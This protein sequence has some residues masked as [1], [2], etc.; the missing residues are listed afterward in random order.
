MNAQRVA[1]GKLSAGLKPAWRFL[2]GKP[3]TSSPVVSN[4]RV[5]IG[6]E[7][8]SLYAVRLTDGKKLWSF[9]TNDIIEATPRVVGDL[10]V[11]GSSD[12]RLYAVNAATGKLAWKYK[13]EDK[14][15][16]AANLAPAQD[17]KGFW[18]VVGSYDNRVHCVR[19]GSGTP[20]W[21]YETDN[22]V[23]GMPAI[24][25]QT[26]VFGGCDGILH[27]VDLR[28]GKREKQIEI[29][30]YIA[31]SATLENGRAYVGHYGNAVVCAELASSK[32]LW[33][34]RDKGFPYFSTPAIQ[35]NTLVIG[36]RDKQVHAIDKNT[37]KNL[38]RFRTN[39]KVDSS[40]VIC[41][42]KVVVGSEDG[43]LYVLDLKSGNPLLRF[44]IGR[45]V[46]SSP[47]IE[48]GTVL[49]GADDGALHAFR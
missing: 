8:K 42:G 30:D 9:K 5:F 17:G 31:G 18:L 11:I 37:G 25:G 24:L 2:T 6:S 32:I 44:P 4:G 35:G 12:G 20:V 10:V 28:T 21:T 33:T 49:I 36:G 43:R 39:G 45:P 1:T 27:L 22:Y 19:A 16:G 40:P 3:I 41:D 14:I 23:N 29:G 13:T 48:Q 7:D 47:W 15:L 34:Y 46:M 38:W 26:V